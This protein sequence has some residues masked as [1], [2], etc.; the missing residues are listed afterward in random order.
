MSHSSSDAGPSGSRMRTSAQTGEL[1]VCVEQTALLL[2]IKVPA[3]WSQPRAARAP[4]PVWT[5][6]CCPSLSRRGMGG[7][8]VSQTSRQ[9]QQC[10]RPCVPHLSLGGAHHGA[11][12]AESQFRPSHLLHC[13]IRG[14]LLPSQALGPLSIQGGSGYSEPVSRSGVAA[15]AAEES[16][17]AQPCVL[18]VLR[19]T[20]PTM[21][22]HQSEGSLRGF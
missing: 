21:W 12:G 5:R 17:R 1:G 7:A 13:A 3:P 2:L 22:N 6:W 9:Q 10:L 18:L 19:A 4:A 16:G 15:G 8:G 14:R 11:P 20:G